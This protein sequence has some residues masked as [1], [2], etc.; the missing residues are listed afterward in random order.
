[1]RKLFYENVLTNDK[2][3]NGNCIDWVHSVG[4]SVHFVYDDI[5]GD[6]LITGYDKETSLVTYIYRHI[7]YTQASTELKK[8][9]LKKMFFNEF[10]YQIGDV[11]SGEYKNQRIKI[12]D[13]KFIET[14]KQRY[15]VYKF[16]CLNCGFNGEKKE[17]EL[18]NN[19]CPCC[20]SSPKITVEGINDIPTQAPW[21]VDY[22]QG[23]YEEAKLYTCNSAKRIQ[24]ICPLCGRIKE[25]AIQICQIYNTKSI[26]CICGDGI[27][28][29]NKIMHSVLKQLGIEYKSEYQPDWLGSNRFDFYVPN[30]MLLIEMDGALGHGK[31]VFDSYKLT[32]EEIECKKIKSLNRDE[33][34]DVLAIKHG[35]QVIRINSD[36]SEIDYI[37]QNILNS[38]LNKYFDLSIIDWKMCDQDALK[39]VVKI[40]CDYYKQHIDKSYEYV[41]NKFYLSKCTV[42]RYLKRGLK[43]GWITKQE[44][45]RILRNNKKHNST[46]VYDLSYNLLGSFSSASELIQVSKDKFGIQFSSGGVTNAV[47]NHTKYYNKYYISYSN[48]IS[49]VC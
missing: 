27:S 7:T 8:C 48:L 13:R 43:V 20:C 18:E 23:G 4:K 11:L 39:N 24:P 47:K 16:Q 41:A 15:K 46:Y 21:M 33:Y 28:Y 45:D 2:F 30:L 44:Y 1:M 25:K 37:K 10:K 17:S 3:R 38:N 32:N 49:E 19:W 42:G 6:I 31:N 5:E 14:E 40:I 26:G 34:K 9:K 36:I 29:P 35:Y 12:T 22:F